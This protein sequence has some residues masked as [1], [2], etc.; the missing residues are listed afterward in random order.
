MMK[1]QWLLC[2]LLPICTLCA[3]TARA[4]RGEEKHDIGTLAGDV[5]NWAML[6]QNYILQLA[7]DGINKHITQSLLDQARYMSEI[8]NGAELVAQVKKELGKYFHNKIQAAEVKKELGKYFHN[9]I[10]A[11]ERLADKVLE[12]HDSFLEQNV[13]VDAERLNDLSLDVYKDSD[14]PARLPDDLEFSPYFLQ[15]VSKKYSTV[16]IADEVPREHQS[17]IN[18]VHFTKGLEKTFIENAETDALLRWQYFG[19]TT[20]VTR[21]Y[22]GREWSTNFAGF[23][24]DYDPRVRPW[25]I[26]A[27]SGPKDV[28][29]VLDCSLSIK[30][31]KFAIAKAVAKNV[32]RTLTKQDYVNVICSRASHWNEVGKWYMYDTD[33]MSCQKKRMVPA[34]N[35][36]RKDLIEKIDKLKAGGTTELQ[37]LGRYDI[38]WKNCVALMCDNANVMTGRNKGVISYVLRKNSEVHLAGCVCHLL[39]ISLKKGMKASSKFDIDDILR[40]LHWY[41]TNI[42]N[43]HQRLKAHQEACGVPAHAIVAHVPTRWLTMGPALLRI[44]EQWEPL[45]KFLE[46]EYMKKKEKGEHTQDAVVTRLRDFFRRRTPKLYKI[47]TPR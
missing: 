27:T 42:I 32:I 13:T 9:K 10:Q 14:I 33:V 15:K 26:A 28:I 1:G 40:Q 35:A 34:T 47:S 39:H 30:G 23:Y 16:K 17:V 8:K 2:V 18:T 11:A 20:G 43:R 6:I 21:L 44:L 31:E 19:S 4:Y 45:Y 36:H 41:I 38:P 46:E 22:P 24:N 7:N 37:C 29:I 5:Q 25:Y 3:D 12:L